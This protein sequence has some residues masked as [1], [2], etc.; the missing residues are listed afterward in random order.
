MKIIVLGAGV[1]GTTSAWYLSQAGHEVTVVDR[2]EGAGLE[3]SFAN[4]GQ[5]SVGHA[6]PWANPGAPLKILKWLA[7]DDAPLLFRPRMDA[8]QWAWCVRFLIECLPS[9]ARRNTGQLLALGLYSRTAL[10]EL[11]ARGN[12]LPVLILTARDSSDSKVA[13]PPELVVSVEVTR[14]VQKRGR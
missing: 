4:G 2:R 10:R 12:R 14:S 7:R 6:E 1:I 3:T 5:I 8:A 9:R 11:R 13:L